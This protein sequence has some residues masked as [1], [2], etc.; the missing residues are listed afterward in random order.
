[1]TYGSKFGVDTRNVPT[2]P[3]GLRARLPLTLGR[4]CVTD[5]FRAD[6]WARDRGQCT[7]K[8]P[9]IFVTSIRNKKRGVLLSQ[10]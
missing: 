4:G 5:S 6:A 10:N 8:K 1:M 9:C 2:A 3:Q 7:T